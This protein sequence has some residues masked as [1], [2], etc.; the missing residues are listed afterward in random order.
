[1]KI[2]YSSEIMSDI[3]DIVQETYSK[4]LNGRAKIP[5]NTQGFFYA[6]IQGCKNIAFD[7]EYQS[8]TLCILDDTLI[9][10]I[11]ITKASSI[12]LHCYLRQSSL[13]CTMYSTY[14]D[15]QVE[16]L[17]IAQQFH[18]R[19]ESKIEELQY[20]RKRNINLSEK[21]Q[22]LERRLAAYDGSTLIETLK[23]IIN[24]VEQFEQEPQEDTNG[25]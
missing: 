14:D 19:P 23:D 21:C 18:E 4:F 3:N 2:R 13:Y 6:V 15:R 25:L 9:I 17:K 1:M 22:R 5:E 20:L 8:R 11:C 10:E 7:N 12:F 24:Q 16:L